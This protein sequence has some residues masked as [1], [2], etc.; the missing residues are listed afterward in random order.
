[1]AK[2]KLETKQQYELE[3]LVMEGKTP[4]DISRIF[5]IAVSSVHNYKRMLKE[6]GVKVPDVRG[7]RPS[8]ITPTPVEI[9]SLPIKVSDNQQPLST[10]LRVEINTVIFYISSNA[11]SVSIDKNSLC[12]EF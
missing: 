12:V 6:K 5:G 9:L 7:K 2:K 3:K 10:H 1:M 11:K 8:N 4:E